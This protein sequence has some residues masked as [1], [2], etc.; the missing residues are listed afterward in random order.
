MH[1]S[2]NLIRKASVRLDRKRLLPRWSF[3][4]FVSTAD[5][6]RANKKILSGRGHRL[7]H[8]KDGNLYYEGNDYASKNLYDKVSSP[9]IVNSIHYTMLPLS[10]TQLVVGKS[11]VFM[12][13][14]D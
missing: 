11:H 13:T 6:M 14:H 8:F 10:P 1:R 7:Q 2:Y 3:C 4:S 5:S 9:G 12:P